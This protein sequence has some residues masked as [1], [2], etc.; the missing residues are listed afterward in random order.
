MAIKSL[1][2]SFSGKI[3]ALR[4]KVSRGA[5]DVSAKAK[6][7][8]RKLDKVSDLW[9]RKNQPA[10]LETYKDIANAAG[11]AYSTAGGYAENAYCSIRKTIR[12]SVDSWTCSPGKI[13]KLQRIIK[14]QGG[15]YRELIKSRKD[16]QDCLF[17]GGESLAVYYTGAQ[18]SDEVLK[19]YEAAYPNLA[20][21]TDLSTLLKGA[22][23]AELT[24]LLSGIKGKLF[25]QKYVEYLNGGNLPD[26]YRAELA[27]S[28]IQPGWDIAI[29]GSNDEIVK[30]LQAK[31][32]E[33]VGYVKE[34][35]ERYPH[36]DVVSTEE[37]YA[38]FAMRAAGEIDVI[39]SG[40]SDVDLEQAMDSAVDASS[41]SMDFSPPWFTLAF[42]A[43]TSYKDE[44]LTL[45]QKAAMAGERS[46]KSYLCYL[47]GG[48]L[49]A[50]T[51]TW[52][53][54]VVGSVSSRYLSDRGNRRRAIFE[55]LKA[56]EETNWRV[57]ERYENL[58]TGLVRAEKV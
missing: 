10:I 48:S 25:E 23:G 30:V 58:P 49:A 56:V 22:D 53:L 19:A 31:A 44:S 55:S 24:G 43:F 17:L 36:I 13:N 29:I 47:V 12:G 5:E 38:Q 2:G 45:Y 57:L 11:V 54:G 41:V 39:N 20:S 15:Y 28:V 18:I 9:R 37:V 16:W 34:A 32:T 4:P 14:A 33:S 8:F 1:L 50:I 26:G 3:D 52:W 27:E 46:G 51:N 21:E 6:R 42:I 7:A 40:M 35:L